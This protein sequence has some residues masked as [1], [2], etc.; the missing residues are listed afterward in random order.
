MED[1][2]MM[3]LQ[4]GSDVRGIALEGV[5]DEH[6]NLTESICSRIGQSFARWLSDKTGKAVSELT[7]GIGRD[8]RVSGPALMDALA[9]G[10]L[11][12]GAQVVRY[13]LWGITGTGIGIAASAFICLLFDLAYTYWR[14]HFVM[15]FSNIILVII[16]G[17][18][19]ALITNLECVF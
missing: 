19:L 10:I 7:I 11:T 12:A 1:K 13:H 15:T 4:N 9:A 5:A 2:N 3:K 17:I 18:A 8:S 16:L 6:I 14:F